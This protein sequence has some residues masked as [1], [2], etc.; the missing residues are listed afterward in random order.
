M[1]KRLAVL[2]TLLRTDARAMVRAWRHKDTPRAFKAGALMLLLYV[3]S[4]IDLVPDF[5]PFVG[6]V[7]DIL[8]ITFG[9]RW[10]LSRLP[11][12]VAA[13]VR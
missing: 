9:I 13:A 8:V 7:D 2:W 10:L 5:I 1:F 3:L 4:P 6:A 12:H 11:A